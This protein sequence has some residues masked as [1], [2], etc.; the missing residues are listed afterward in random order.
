[1]YQSVQNPRL[2]SNPWEWYPNSEKQ[3]HQRQRKQVV[4]IAVREESQEIIVSI[5]SFF[6][7]Y[8]AK[9]K[10]RELYS[11]EARKSNLPPSYKFK[12]MN[13]T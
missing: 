3:G 6:L 12:K 11:H 4:N 9:I 1:M 10:E 7:E 5:W 13:F 8:I 2:K